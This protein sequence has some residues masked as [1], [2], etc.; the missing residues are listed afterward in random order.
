MPPVLMFGYKFVFNGGNYS[1]HNSRHY[2]KNGNAEH[3]TVE[4]ENL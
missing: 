3:Y 2:C 1:V 4:L